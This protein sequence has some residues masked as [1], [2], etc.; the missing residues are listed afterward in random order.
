MLDPGTEALPG[1]DRA[2]EQIDG[3]LGLARARIS[4]ACTV[5]AKPFAAAVLL[6][7]VAAALE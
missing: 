4:D 3:F 7:A 6:S 2:V 5:L 1:P